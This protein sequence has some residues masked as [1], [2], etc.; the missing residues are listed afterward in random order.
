MWLEA[1]GAANQPT[2]HR[3][4]L[5]NK[6]HPAQDVTSAEVGKHWVKQMV[7]K[8][9]QVSYFLE[10]DESVSSSWLMANDSLSEE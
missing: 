1:R 5:Y 4:N 8:L 10:I 3:I 7:E 9:E 6:E 2:G